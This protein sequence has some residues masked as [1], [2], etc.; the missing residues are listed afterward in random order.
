M[1]SPLRRRGEPRVARERGGGELCAARRPA[2]RRVQQMQPFCSC[3][4]FSS[5]CNS[6]VSR[7]CRRKR[8][9]RARGLEA[10]GRVA[11][12]RRRGGGTHQRGV[13]VDCRHVV[14]DH[15]YLPA[16]LVLQNIAQESRLARTEEAC[17]R[18]VRERV[19]EHRMARGRLASLKLCVDSFA[20]RLRGVSRARRPEAWLLV[21]SWPSVLAPCSTGWTYRRKENQKLVLF[22][23]CVQK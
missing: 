20:P 10:P 11:G 12:R 9:R 15:S 19:P 8:E 4:S 5:F 23:M 7:I 17:G 1:R 2:Y 13:D 22:S 6:L 3:T 21:A 18:A 14:D 16:L